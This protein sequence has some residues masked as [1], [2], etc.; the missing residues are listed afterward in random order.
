MDAEDLHSKTTALMNSIRPRDANAFHAL[1]QMYGADAETVINTRRSCDDDGYTCVTHAAIFGSAKMMRELLSAGADVN[2]VWKKTGDTP[3][4][5]L[6]WEACGDDVN[7]RFKLVYAHPST[8]RAALVYGVH[9]IPSFL[10]GERHL[11][12]LKAFV[13]AFDGRQHT[14]S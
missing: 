6:L 7:K 4:T 2:V 9:T 1:M 13:N 10:K 14:L 3:L 8:N 11:R 5:L 12:P